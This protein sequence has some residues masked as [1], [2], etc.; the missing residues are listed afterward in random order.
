MDPGFMGLGCMGLMFK[1][2]GS[3]LR[4]SRYEFDNKQNDCLGF[5]V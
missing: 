3:R 4:E 1:V 2:E 5:M